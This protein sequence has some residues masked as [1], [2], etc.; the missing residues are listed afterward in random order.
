MN[1]PQRQLLR[2][3]STAVENIREQL[4]DALK[5][6]REGQRH[7]IRQIQESLAKISNIAK[8]IAND[9]R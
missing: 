8:E 6:D 3:I 5:Y 7:V 1:H 4:D 2:N 9:S